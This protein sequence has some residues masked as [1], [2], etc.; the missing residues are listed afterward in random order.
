MRLL[1]RRVPTHE[2]LMTCFLA[3]IGGYQFPSYRNR[4]VELAVSEQGGVE[5]FEDRVIFVL[6]EYSSSQNR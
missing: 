3:W 5:S 4:W 2:Q 6:S 1:E